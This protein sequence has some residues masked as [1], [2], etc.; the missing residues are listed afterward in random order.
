MR[1]QDER[2]EVENLFRA[3]RGLQK[4][5]ELS[6]SKLEDVEVSLAALKAKVEQVLPQLLVAMEDLSQRQG[7]GGLGVGVADGAGGV[8]G[9]DP[10]AQEAQR[11][12]SPYLAALRGFID[13]NAVPA[14]FASLDAL[15]KGLQAAEDGT[16]D[17]LKELR[18]E[19]LNV[20]AGKADED[21][22]RKL[23]GQLE[24][25]YR[26]LRSM[27]QQTMS[28]HLQESSVENAALVRL[29]L[30]PRRCVSCDK[31]V[32]LQ[33]DQKF[34]PYDKSSVPAA[35]WPRR[36]QPSRLAPS[37]GPIGSGAGAAARGMAGGGRR[38]PTLP[39]VESAKGADSAVR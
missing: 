26:E 8:D 2:R 30:L 14:P 10:S 18:K 12:P 17:S 3:L 28:A 36:E 11:A 32:D 6:S 38:E 33:F 19:L 24:S 16:Q 9:G 35:G 37:P 29:P 21:A 13:R 4:D 25:A 15:S 22:L 31:P 27:F 23:A 7:R 5:H 34:S 1:A 20:L 39:G